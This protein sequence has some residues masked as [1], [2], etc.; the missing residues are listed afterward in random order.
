M[1]LSI[2]NHNYL[3]I[4]SSIAFFGTVNLN[5]TPV[6]HSITCP[7]HTTT[8]SP[9]KNKGLLEPDKIE[10]IDDISPEDSA[11]QVS[12]TSTLFRHAIKEC[13]E[14]QRAVF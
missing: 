10:Q 13:E 7:G 2:T 3:T 12:M 4:G 8:K 6:G 9:P 5:I 14:H 1:A 11:S